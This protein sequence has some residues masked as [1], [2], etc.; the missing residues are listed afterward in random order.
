MDTAPLIDQPVVEHKRELALDGEGRIAEDLPCRGCGYNLRGHAADA[1]CPECSALVN[2]SARGDLLPFS[3][4]DWLERLAK[5]MRLVLIGLVAAT[6]LQIGVVAT[7]FATVGSTV[8]AA[9]TATAGLLGAG[10]SVVVVVGV[11]WL[12]TPDPARGDRERALSIRRLTRWCLVAQIAAVP[13][14]VVSP[15]GGVGATGAGPPFGAAFVSLAMA[16]LAMWLVVLVGYAAAFV[17]LRRLALRAPKPSLARQT[18]IVM[19]GYLSSQGL[20]AVVG[21]LFLFVFSAAVLG[22]TAGPTVPMVG[23]VISGSAVTLGSLVFGIWAL[24]LLFGYVALLKNAARAARAA[25]QSAGL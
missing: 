9:L 3:D 23:I 2:L 19:W 15:T 20:G 24:V 25:W 5:G 12:T 1:R 8:F 16:G 4:P 21:M 10:S 6:V 17:Y 18:K 22:G 14:E 11:W 13:L 7:S